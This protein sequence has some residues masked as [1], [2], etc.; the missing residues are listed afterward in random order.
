VEILLR[1]LVDNALR[2]TP[3]GGQILIRLDRLE[4]GPQRDGGHALWVLDDGPGI[5]EEDMGRV[6]T[7]FARGGSVEEEGCGLGLSIVARIVTMMDG[8]LSLEPGLPHPQGGHGLGV[9]V[10]LGSGGGEVA[11]DIA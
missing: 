2:Y 3:A 7:R 1:N 5:A 10:V 11:A 8:R 9:R 6:L 4:G